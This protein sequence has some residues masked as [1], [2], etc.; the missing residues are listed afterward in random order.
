MSARRGWGSGPGHVLEPESMQQRVTRFLRTWGFWILV[1]IAWWSVLCYLGGDWGKLWI[2]ASFFAFFY[3]TTSDT[4]GVL[5]PR[6]RAFGQLTSHDFDRMRGTAIPLDAV[7]STTEAFRSLAGTTTSS[8]GG[9]GGS[10]SAAAGHKLGASGA[11]VE[12]NSS[13]ALLFKLNA[14]RLA[15][16][17]AESRA[18]DGGKT[19]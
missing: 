2:F 19:D 4:K 9:G 17:V 15:R 1:A 16:R 12:D 11:S 18:A 7:D 8:A 14:E 10:T 13:A 6:E 5:F 3:A